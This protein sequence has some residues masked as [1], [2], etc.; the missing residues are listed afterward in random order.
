MTFVKG[1]LNSSYFGRPLHTQ[2]I[3][4]NPQ[5]KLGNWETLTLLKTNAND[6]SVIVK[7]TSLAPINTTVCELF[8]GNYLAKKDLDTMFLSRAKT[9]KHILQKSI[10]KFSRHKES[11]HT[12][13]LNQIIVDTFRLGPS[14]FSVKGVEVIWGKC[15]E[16]NL[17]AAKNALH[18]LKALWG[19]VC[20]GNT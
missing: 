16:C 18:S 4:I 14:L 7:I 20:E 12:K 19:P 11:E 17:M 8:S 13:T 3:N 10:P 5:K 15:V 9:E 6:N 1:I 2:I